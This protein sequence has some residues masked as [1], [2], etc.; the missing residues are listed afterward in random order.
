VTAA[1]LLGSER[2]LED[3]NGLVVASIPTGVSIAIGAQVVV[4]WL[5]DRTKDSSYGELIRVVDPGESR[6]RLPYQVVTGA[7][8]LTSGLGLFVAFTR[9]EFPRTVEASLYSV[10]VALFVYD[11]LGLASLFAISARHA[12]RASALQGISEEAERERRRPLR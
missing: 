10:L 9:G 5:G 11:I 2:P 6:A 7:G 12:K 1:L 3:V 8:L 4:R